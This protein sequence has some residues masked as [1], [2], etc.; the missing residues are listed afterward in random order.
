V[1]EPPPESPDEVEQLKAE[2][3]FTTS[4][5]PQEGQTVFSPELIR[6]RTEKMSLQLLQI[7]S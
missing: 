5:E 4:S 6:L 3:F 7:Y 1:N 2:S